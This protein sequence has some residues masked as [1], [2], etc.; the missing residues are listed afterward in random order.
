M[1]KEISYQYYVEGEDE[2]KLLNVLKRD[3]RCIKSGKVDKFN[4]IQDYFT[5]A[6]IRP[7]KQNT[8]V[9]LV[10]DTDIEKIEILRK[11]ITF[12][13]NQCAVKDV[14]CIP[15]VKKFEHELIRACEIRNIMEL[16]HSKTE[17]DFKRDLISCTNLCERLKKCKFDIAKFWNCDP[18]NK[19][20]VWRNDADK[21][22]IARR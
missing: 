5:T 2:K 21:I 14:L 17:K 3:L 18:Q 20:S 1:R 13:Q 16:T 6:R 22:K 12:L 8:I 10:Y 19:F 4:V 9:I 11:N 7:L 15:Q